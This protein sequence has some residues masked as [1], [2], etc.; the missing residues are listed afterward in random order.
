MAYLEIKVREG[1]L[2]KIKLG[3]NVPNQIVDL[4]ESDKQIEAKLEMNYHITKFFERQYR[5]DEKKK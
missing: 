5:K 2:T 1:K 3:F 4:W